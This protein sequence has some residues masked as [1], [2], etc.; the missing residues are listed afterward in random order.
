MIEYNKQNYR[1][2]HFSLRSLVR[3]RISISNTF[4]PFDFCPLQNL[5]CVYSIF[6]FLFVPGFATPPLLLLLSTSCDSTFIICSIHFHS[7]IILLLF[8]QCNVYSVYTPRCATTAHTHTLAGTRIKPFPSFL[9]KNCCWNGCRHNF[10][11][12]FA[13]TVWFAAHNDCYCV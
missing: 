7:T 1:V 13:F 12:N 8:R 11:L 3:F 6:V 10:Y 4:V 2:T 5:P 9:G